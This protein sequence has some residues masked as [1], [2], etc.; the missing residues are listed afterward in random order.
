[1]SKTISILGCGWLGFPLAKQLVNKGWF[2]NGSTTS[3]EKIT[4]LKAAGINSFLID[5]SKSETLKTDFFKVNYLLI[6]IPPSKLFREVRTYTPL[7]NAISKSEVTKVIFISSTSVYPALNQ[8][9][10]E[11]DT[12]LIKDGDNALLDIE[13]AFQNA[14]FDT[15]ILRFGGLVGGER[16]PGRFF[17]ASK[18]IK[19]ANQPV[20]LIHLYDCIQIIEQ[21]IAKDCF[22]QVFNGVAD[23]HPG[24]KEFYS[25]A[26]ALKGGKEL[27]FNDE[28]IPYKIIS[29]KKTKRL[30][31]IT[32]QYPD[33]LEML[34][35]N[36]L[37]KRT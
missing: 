30:L 26:T 28:K 24:R 2:V 15:T 23:S 19:G 32:F 21:V 1:M 4:Q 6:N 13:R 11:E 10:Y 7:I 33:L 25:L 8:V 37:W 36:S 3:N 20:N 27:L 35:D 22:G 34:R 5:I 29:N 12:E 9:A 16:Y 14:E 31:N 18:V 17:S